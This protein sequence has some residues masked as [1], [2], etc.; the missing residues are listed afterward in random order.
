MKSLTSLIS[1]PLQ[2]FQ[3]LSY[4]YHYE[5][6]AS[7][8]AP[9]MVWQEGGENSFHSDNSKSE[10]ALEGICE[11]FTQTECDPKLDEIEEALEGMGASWM[12]TAVQFE[13]ESELIHYSWDWSVT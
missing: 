8:S 7:A 4:S 3:S 9:Y 6:P 10:R 13:S 5:K 1:L 12:L 11:F 2:A